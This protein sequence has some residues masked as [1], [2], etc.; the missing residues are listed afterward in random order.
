[1][2]FSVGDK[3]MH[4]QYGPGR[5]THVQHRELVEGFE[6]YYVIELSK[7]G[8]TLFVPV[9]KSEELGMRPVMSRA[10]ISR[11]LETLRAVPD[12][13]SKDFKKR[14]TRIREKLATARPIKVAEAVRD[15]TWR[16]HRKHLTKVDKELLDRGRDI[17]AEEM[18]L[19]SGTDAIYAHQTMDT[20]LK[21]AIKGQRDEK[22]RVSLESAALEPARDNLVQKL[23]SRVG[24]HEG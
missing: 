10:K 2:Q 11:V 20:V 9:R 1:M 3:V 5:I 22:E 16:R 14:Q 18:A 13:L 15:L 4:P 23:F 24:S 21:S 7:N 19:A 6:H 8:S 12:L 17:L